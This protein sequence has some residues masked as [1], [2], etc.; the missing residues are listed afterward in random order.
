MTDRAALEALMNG[1]MQA[2]P[3][4]TEQRCPQCGKQSVTVYGVFRRCVTPGCGWS[5]LVR[6][7]GASKS[8]RKEG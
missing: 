4:M 2:G 1:P 7:A 5:A 6:Y 3:R 8:A